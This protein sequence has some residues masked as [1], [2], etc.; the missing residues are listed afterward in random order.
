MSV[1]LSEARSKGGRR[2]LVALQVKTQGSPQPPRARLCPLCVIGPWVCHGVRTIQIGLVCAKKCGRLRRT[3]LHRC[4]IAAEAVYDGIPV[5]LAWSAARTDDSTPPRSTSCFLPQSP[6][7]F[8]LHVF[9]C[10][11]GRFGKAFLLRSPAPLDDEARPT[12]QSKPPF[13][14]NNTRALTGSF[15]LFLLVRKMPPCLY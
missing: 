5:A 7:A 13:P 14:Q 11:A 8:V 15:V 2:F 1:S 10:L 3:K 12:A 6:E 4:S 9:V